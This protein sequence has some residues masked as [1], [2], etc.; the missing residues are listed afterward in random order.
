[1]KKHK[2]ILT[3]L[4][5]FGSFILSFTGRT[6]ASD[7]T[8]SSNTTLEPGTYTHDNVLITNGA[9]LTCNGAV[10][11]NAA[12]LS[13]DAGSTI[14]ADGKGFL[15]G[16]G[17]GAGGANGAGGGYGGKGRSHAGSLGG[18]TYGSALAPVD[19][20]S[21]GGAT[22]WN[23]V[24][25]GSGGGAIRINI[26]ETLT[27]NGLISANGNEFSKDSYYAGGGSGGSVY[28]TTK[29]FTGGGKITVNGGG[30]TSVNAGGG[31]GGG[32]IAVYYQT[33]TFAGKTEAKGGTGWQ[34]GEDGTIVFQPISLNTPLSSFNLIEKSSTTATSQ[35]TL[36]IQQLILN[37]VQITGDL[38]GTLNFTNLTLTTLTSGAFLDKGFFEAEFQTTLEG[39]SYQGTLQ[40]VVYPDTEENKL[41]LKASIS[42]LL[43]SG[44]AEATLTESTP[45][46]GVYDKYQA[47]WKLNRLGTDTLSATLNLESTVSSQSTHSFTSNLYT[48]QG[49]YE[50]NCIGSYT[51]PLSAVLTHLRLTSENEYKGKGFSILS[52]NSL[53]GQG[54][55]YSYNQAASEGLIEFHGLFKPLLGRLSDTILDETK[56]PKTLTGTIESLDLGKAPT[57][58]L[59]V[60][61]WGPTRVSPGQTFDYII[62][63]RN[64]GLKAGENFIVV[65]ELPGQTTYKSSTGGGIY[66]EYSRNVV[67]NFE[68]LGAKTK[69]Y[70]TTK[71]EVVWGLAMSSFVGNIVSIPKEDIK[72]EIDPSITMSNEVQNVSE[73]TIRMKTTFQTPVES[74]DMYSEITI[75]RNWREQ[76]E[77]TLDVYQ[78]IGGRTRTILNYTRLPNGSLLPDKVTVALNATA[79][80]MDWIG[81]ARGYMDTG[82]EAIEIIEDDL[83]R[84]RDAAYLYRD[85]K[86]DERGLEDLQEKSR[87]LMALNAVVGLARR[88]PGVGDWF[89]EVLRGAPQAGER[90]YESV[91]Q[92]EIAYKP[93]YA[94][95][96][97]NRRGY[98]YSV[99]LHT[100]EVTLARD[101]NELLVSPEG[102]VR[103]GAK[104]SY[105]VNYENE[106]EG[107]AYGVYVTDTLLDNLDDSSLVVNG[108]GKYDPATRTITWFIGELLSKQKGSVTFSVNVK[109]DAHDKS[110]VINFAT[111]YF[112]SVP[113][114]TRTNGTVNRITTATD[115]TAPTTT[116]AITPASNQAGWNNSD[117]TITLT[118][119]DNEGGSGV[120]KT[121]YSL[122]NINWTTYTTPFN[123]TAEGTTT[124]Y[125]KSTDNLNNTESP[126]PLEIKIDK[127]PPAI[128]SQTLPSPNSLGWNNTDVTVSFVAS[129]TLSG[130]ASITQP[131]TITTEGANQI[132]GGQAVDLADYT[133]STSVTLSIDKNPPEVIITTPQE[134][135]E[136]LL[137][138]AV[139]ANWSANDSLSWI[140]SSTG[141][142]PSGSSLDT[143][144]VGTK[145]FSVTALDNASNKT[146]KT[147]TYYVRYNYSGILP[148]INADGSSIFKL[149]RTIPVKFQLKDFSGSFISAAIAK[150]YLAKISND[151]LGT[152]VE[153]ESVGEANTGNLFRYD[154]T[155]NQYIFNLGTS[156]LSEGI[157]QIRIS[158]DDGTSKYVNIGLK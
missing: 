51:G 27:L 115:T 143:F 102:D 74:Q 42:G 136:Y 158:L 145:S 116:A 25:G 63:L 139:I 13:V 28:I 81:R 31:G 120:S 59:K 5:I 20:G 2:K 108:G 6:F 109:A 49:N 123:I 26:S 46:S 55:G 12:S 33:S 105:T 54:E 128:A 43:I 64:D 114:T 56:N 66:K 82:M 79:T 92:R 57:P 14:S 21:G 7:I 157:W 22:G 45:G 69:Q 15:S 144:T 3:A 39:S 53:L 122:D 118:A 23:G 91:V 135:A 73:N 126:K 130:I 146:E 10:T 155:N 78:E 154:T 72:I 18:S 137:N 65:D 44:I 117:V 24:P 87:I 61:I 67:W 96:E 133:S 147:I 153:A 148:P 71:G 99:S 149:G 100:S 152:E 134:A 90:L 83:V 112:P 77:P 35:E 104:L 38:T 124:V 34:N 60:K 141:T 17:P 138:Q 93:M 58:D 30:K 97:E 29:N 151:V 8:I 142:A 121:E 103:P 37:N 110:E 125:Y 113:E 52:Y 131:Q 11:L 4:L 75:L 140:A 41:C 19:L 107:D 111:V 80:T 16:Q 1:M 150:L 50:G 127:T 156:F 76:M 119:Q 48:Y 62:E 89:G 32:R 9:I 98:S 68:N 129:D 36:S 70:I 40:G 86:I 106:G 132:I 47:T 101:P 94:A 95:I 85:G 88:I 84:Q